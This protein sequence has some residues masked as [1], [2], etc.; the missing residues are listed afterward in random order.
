MTI[1]H[2]LGVATWLTEEPATCLHFVSV[3]EHVRQM[4]ANRLLPEFLDSHKGGQRGGQIDGHF[5]SPGIWA[6]TQFYSII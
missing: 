3:S 5:L 4:L 1:S 2:F 6:V